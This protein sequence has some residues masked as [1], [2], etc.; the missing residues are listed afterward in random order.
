[1]EHGV[2]IMIQKLSVNIHGGKL[3]HPQ[4]LGKMPRFRSKREVFISFFHVCDIV[5]APCSPQ[6]VRVDHIF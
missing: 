3:Q 5:H 4:D 2:S 6:K 1:M